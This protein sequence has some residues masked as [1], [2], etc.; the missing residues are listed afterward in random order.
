[1]QKIKVVTGYIPIPGVQNVDQAG[2][3]ELGTRLKLCCTE[4]QVNV[5][6]FD[7]TTPKSLEYCWLLRWLSRQP[8]NEQVK[9]SDP[10]PDPVR[11]ANPGVK[12]ISNIVMHQ[13]YEWLALAAI[14]DPEPDVLVWIDYGVL[15]Q[16]KMTED[17]VIQCL[18]RIAAA[19]TG[20]EIIAPGVRP[21]VEEPDP[22]QS[23]D[24]FCGSLV[25]VPRSA[26]FN[27]ARHMK[28]D[29][30]KTIAESKMVTIETNTLARLEFQGVIPIR[31]VQSWWGASMF[32][33]IK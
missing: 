15:K 30:M 1:M 10:A 2:F 24:R 31:W 4:A 8:W 17:T 16:E 32:D 20:H 14:N 25:I 29:A 13:K 18:A 5:E 33:A 3:R 27:L 7:M 12:L 26:L 23:W 21:T 6:A 19:P 9:C 22:L 11:F 28:L